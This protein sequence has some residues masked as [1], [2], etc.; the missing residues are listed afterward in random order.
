MNIRTDDAYFPQSVVSDE[1]YIFTAWQNYDERN[2]ELVSFYGS[3]S[4]DGTNWSDPFLLLEPFQ[5]RGEDKVSLFTLAQDKNGNPLI[6]LMASENSISIY[7]LNTP[8]N[9]LELISSIETENTSVVPRIFRRFDNSLIL[10]MTGSVTL[11]NGTDAL[12]I[13]YSVSDEG[14]SWSDAQHF[15]RNS[16]LKQNFLPF[17]CFDNQGEYVVFQSLYTGSRNTYQIYLKSLK[18]GDSLWSDEILVTSYDEYI[19]GENIEFTQFDNQRPHMVAENGTLHLVWERRQGRAMPQI[20]YGV[21]NSNGESLEEIEQISRGSYFTASPRI[22]RDNGESLILWFDNRNNNQVILAKRNGIF[23]QSEIVSSTSGNST[24]ARWISFKG[25][26]FAI[27]ENLLNEN[28]NI[29]ILTPDKTASPPIIRT[30]NFTDQGRQADDRVIL[31]WRRPQDSSGIQGFSYVWDNNTD[32]EP[33]RDKEYLDLRE[34]T[35]TFRAIED[36]DWYFHIALVDYAGNW[37][38]TVHIRIT[39]DTIPP[40][41]VQFFKPLTDARGYLISNTFTLNWSSDDEHLGG[42]SYR[43]YFLGE[44][45][46]FID[47]SKLDLPSPPET[48]QT[49]SPAVQYNNRDNGH[50]ALSVSAF[51]DVGNRSE[52]SILLFRTDKYIPVTYIS[53]VRTQKD[54]LERVVLTIIGRGFSVGGKV[55]RVV[56]DRDGKAPWDYEFTADSFDVRTDRVIEGP[57]VEVFEEG[58]YL[59]GV[60]HPGRGFAFAK[61]KLRLDSTGTVRFGDFSYDYKTFWLPIELSQRIFSMNSLMFYL[62]I[63]LLVSVCALSSWQISRIMKENSKLEEDIQ[64]IISG[65]PLKS[66]LKKERMKSMKR[67]GMGLRMK[68]TLALLTLILAVIL[69]ISIFLGNYMINTQK[70]NLSVGLYDKSALLLETLT[71]SARTYLPTQN[72]L[73]LGLLPNTIR[74]MDEAVNTTISGQGANNPDNFNYIWSSN[75]KDIEKYQEFPSTISVSRVDYPENW[76]NGTINSFESKYREGDNFSFIEYEEDDRDLIY[77]L[78]SEAGLISRFE[79]GITRVD[80]I[81]SE[82]IDELEK[83]INSRALELI[84]DQS[85][86][87]DQ[88]SEDAV[89]LAIRGDRASLDELAVIQETISRI[90][91]EINDKLS[92]VSNI[93]QTYPEFII[94]TLSDEKLI[95]TFYKPVVYRNKGRDSYFRGIVRLDVSI[96]SILEGIIETQNS[97]LRITVII[98]LLALAGGLVGAFLLA[99]TMINPIKKLVEGVAKVRDTQDK[100][101]LKN[102]SIETGTRDEL[103]DLATTFN[104][105]TEGLVAAA[106]ANKSLILGKEIQKKF[107]PLDPVPQSDRKYT[108]GEEENERVH[109]FGYYEGAK[110]VS[111]DYFDYKRLDD[112]H[113]ATIKCD[114]SGKDIPASLIMVQVATLFKDY[115]SKLDIRRDGIHLEVLVNNINDLIAQINFQGKFAAFIVAVI[116]IETGKCWICHAGDNMFYYYDGALKKVIK[117]EMEE[118]PAAGMFGTDI[119]GE[120]AFKQINHTLKNDDFLFLFTDG[121]EEAKRKFRTKDLEII[122]C[123]GTCDSSILGGEKSKSHI[124]GSDNEELGLTRIEEI[125]DAVLNKSTYQIYQYHQ[126]DKDI[127]LSFDFR[128][129]IGDMKETVLALISVEKVFRLY[130]DPNAGP[131]DRIRIDNK[132]DEFLKVHFDQ[133]RDYFKYPIPDEDYPEYTYYS[134]M[135]EEPQYDDL[136]ILGIHKK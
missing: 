37:S 23:W 26:L 133:Y 10:F 131:D 47:P 113:Y 128:Q 68:F 122:H 111:G 60:E 4:S 1:G 35:E 97:I 71:T 34:R 3:I 112:K 104:Q 69:L 63:A 103:S 88:L 108:T 120:T 25:D 80:D 109:F 56:L 136:T 118:A 119:I 134:H 54:D 116:N 44:D 48:V 70:E 117:K 17:Y 93:V 115:F 30:V 99:Q 45:A 49:I 41:P 78:L 42:F 98:S 102:Y 77:D 92:T 135:K 12:S 127:K 65:A 101:K 57:V 130:P 53:D 6:S 67:R 31:T 16:E 33:D 100:S 72:R 50:W 24:Y 129:G 106:V 76:T 29:V 82:V 18:N 94:E 14:L 85:S 125:M 123:D 59:V 64:S 89:R 36:G 83:D 11:P 124:E 19:D 110:G 126:P 73:E 46:D 21:F 86:Q 5:Y 95:Y 105:M 39:R 62:L 43:F 58:Y 61:G 7:R 75:N 9:P 40:S 15:I 91:T 13:H 2:S 121:I 22:T 27:W 96:N 28:R 79:P 51:D 32:T 87:L 38:D 81:L 90:E 74:A 55:Q 8:G 84:G 114:I 20:H 107:L 132:V 66:H 52:P